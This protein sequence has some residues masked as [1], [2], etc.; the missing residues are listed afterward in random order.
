[1][2]DT[3]TLK[4]IE[5]SINDVLDTG[6]GISIAVIETS[7]TCEIGDLVIKRVNPEDFWNTRAGGEE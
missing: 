4:A 5:D 7:T 2:T 6:M 3:Q 1:M